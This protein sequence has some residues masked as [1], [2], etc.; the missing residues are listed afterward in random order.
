MYAY[1]G[2]PDAETMLLFLNPS[3]Q[4]DMP[5]REDFT[6]NSGPIVESDRI[7]QESAPFVRMGMVAALLELLFPI[8]DRFR[9]NLWQKNAKSAKTM[10][11]TTPME[12]PIIS[13][14]DSSFISFFLLC[15]PLYIDHPIH[16]H[17]WQNRNINRINKNMSLAIVKSWYL[18][19]YSEY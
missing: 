5:F 6:G 8:C 16:W 4:K 19:H 10:P 2:S 15:Y 18:V 11:I 13:P 9:W 7:V 1:S 12:T 17:S 14:I 3:S